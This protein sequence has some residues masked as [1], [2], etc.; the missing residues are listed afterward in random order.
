MLDYMYYPYYLSLYILLK[1]Y[2]SYIVNMIDLFDMNGHICLVFPILGEST[3]DFKKANDFL[4]YQFNDVKNMAS[5]AQ[6]HRMY[7]FHHWFRRVKSK[8]DGRGSK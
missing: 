1:I 8:V 6:S 5:N 3:Y 4:P 7:V 2:L